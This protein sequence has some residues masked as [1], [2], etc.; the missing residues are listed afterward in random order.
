MKTELYIIASI[1]GWG[2]GSFVY[3]SAN[4]AL[5]P[6][7][8]LTITL[9]LYVILLPLLWIFIKFDT[10]VTV[11]GIVYT[12]IGAAFMCIGTLGFSF[13]LR[14]G[15]PAGQI[16]AICACYPIITVILSCIFLG[17]EFNIK[18]LIGIILTLSGIIFLALK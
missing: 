3:K 16:T 8:G 13:A 7:M 17:E 11:A 14:N 10:E 18:K 5:H 2:I 9:I 6:I 15:G 12:L 1:L 4:T